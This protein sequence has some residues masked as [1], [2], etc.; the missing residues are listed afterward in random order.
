MG[1]N[2]RNKGATTAQGGGIEKT[3]SVMNTPEGCSI[4]EQN[5]AIAE[6]APPEAQNNQKGA[7]ERGETC[8]ET[9]HH[10]RVGM[11]ERSRR[12]ETPACPGPRRPGARR[13]TQQAET[14]EHRAPSV[15][16]EARINPAAAV[17]QTTS[18]QAL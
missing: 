12:R 16:K 8:R 6:R 14:R 18:E 17:N 9:R 10:E 15:R 1:P 5:D 13:R 11:R 7:A 2:A 4:K 3:Q